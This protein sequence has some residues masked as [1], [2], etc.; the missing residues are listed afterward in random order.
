MVNKTTKILKN[1]SFQLFDV[2]GILKKQ[3][4]SLIVHRRVNTQ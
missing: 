4:V 3:D 1:Q 2:L